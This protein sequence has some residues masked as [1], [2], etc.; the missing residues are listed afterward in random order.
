MTRIIKGILID[1][2]ACT[3]TEVER[4]GDL[5]DDVYRLLSHG[6]EPVTT[7]NCFNSS[8]LAPGD[9]IYVDDDVNIN[10]DETVSSRYNRFFMFPG[11]LRPFAGK[12]LIFGVDGRGRAMDAQTKISYVDLTTF[13][14]EQHEGKFVAVLEPIEPGGSN[15]PAV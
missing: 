2:F 4:D 14:L 6:D 9:S 3:V 7:F 15:A 11:F 10:E 5:L 8:Q 1:P 12:G 13:F